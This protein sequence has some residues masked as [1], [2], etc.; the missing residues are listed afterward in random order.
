MCAACFFNLFFSVKSNVKDDIFELQI[1]LLEMLT[2][3]GAGSIL[4][5]QESLVA[6]APKL[7]I[8]NIVQAL[9]A[10]EITSSHY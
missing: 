5:G 9:E 6:S 2:M 10:E 7:T 8:S 1:H 4:A 3:F